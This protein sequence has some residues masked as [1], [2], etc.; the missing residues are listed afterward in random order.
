MFDNDQGT[1]PLQNKEIYKWHVGS[2]SLAFV[3]KEFSIW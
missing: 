3:V 1:F 2:M